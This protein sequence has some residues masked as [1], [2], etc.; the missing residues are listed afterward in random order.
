ME[1][2][3]FS[4]CVNKFFSTGENFSVTTCQHGKKGKICKQV[5][6]RIFLH[7]PQPLWKSLPPGVASL[8]AAGGGVK[9]RRSGC[10]GRQMTKPHR[11][12]GSCRAPQTEWWPS[13]ARSDEECGRKTHC[14][15]NVADVLECCAFSP[16]RKHQ[17]AA[18]NLSYGPRTLQTT[19]GVSEPVSG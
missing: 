3:V 19:K 15:Y 10:R 14:W 6:H 7:N 9:G 8:T 13:V 5:L 2:R 18:E 11:R 17:R 4:C 12:Q 16:A 1:K